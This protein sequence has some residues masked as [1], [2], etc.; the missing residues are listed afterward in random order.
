MPKMRPKKLNLPEIEV[1][2][3]NPTV[4][5][6]QKAIRKEE[7]N[8]KKK[9]RTIRIVVI[10]I[11][12][13][14]LVAFVTAYIYFYSTNSFVIE[15]I[16]INGVKHLTNDEMNQLIAVEEGETLL[17]VDTDIITKRL[18]QDAWIEDVKIVPVFPST[19]QINVTEREITAIV[20]VPTSSDSLSSS[21]SATQSSVIRNWAIAADHMWLMPIPDK[22]SEASKNINQQIYSD[23]DGVMHIVDVSPG[24]N[25]EIGS[26]SSDDSV[27]CAIDVV[28]AMTTDLKNQV[29][30]VKAT[31]PNSTNLILNNGVEIAIGTSENLREKERVC[32]KLLEENEGKISYI[33]VRNANSPTWRR[34]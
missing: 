32:Q 18:K 14:A 21:S 12:L 26:Y 3:K 8:K 16:E 13:A 20:E 9:A 29:K 30:N 10:S 17:K 25:P 7:H 33:N 6:R 5:K 11:V 31:D 27:N 1:D 4:V 34:I 23:V 2:T 24:V 22:N 15:N 28:D 19:L